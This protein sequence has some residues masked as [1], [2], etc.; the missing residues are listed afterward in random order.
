MSI[1]L[2]CLS[3]L[4]PVA[5]LLALAFAEERAFAALASGARGV[6]V[7]LAQVVAEGIPPL[8]REGRGWWHLEQRRVLEAPDGWA[9]LSFLPCC[10]RTLEV[11]EQAWSS[12]GQITALSDERRIVIDAAAAGA[13]PEQTHFQRVDP[14]RPDDGPE[15]PAGL[16]ESRLIDI[17]EQR[18]ADQQRL[19]SRWP[20]H[21][22]RGHIL[23]ER[24]LADGQSLTLCGHLRVE[25]DAEH[26]VAVGGYCP[27][28]LGTPTEVAG[29][30]R[31]RRL[32]LS[33]LALCIVVA[34]IDALLLGTML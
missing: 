4:V 11:R 34:G 30:L 7:I 12:A 16:E 26:L 14:R 28:A 17:T 8:S 9:A 27:V 22:L 31:R 33:Y 6:E 2:A 10:R 21:W 32:R 19:T 18:H 15:L 5:L 13:L 24:S 25:G 23:R 1:C 20:R 3:L 29:R